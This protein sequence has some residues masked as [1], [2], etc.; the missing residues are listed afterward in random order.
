MGHQPLEIME[1]TTRIRQCTQGHTLAA[2]EVGD[3]LHRIMNEM[4]KWGVE[5]GNR[6]LG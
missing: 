2:I 4:A 6:Y 3:A 5:G 1:T